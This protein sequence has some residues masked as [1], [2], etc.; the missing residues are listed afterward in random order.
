MTKRVIV[1]GAS[2]GIGKE[3]AWIL[4][5]SHCELVLVARR[6]DLLREIAQQCRDRGAVSA[7]VIAADLSES[8]ATCAE[9]IQEAIGP[10]ISPLVL[11]NNAGTAEFGPYAEMDW[12][13]IERSMAL[14]VLG[15]MRLCHAILPEMLARGGGQIVNVLS[16]AATHVFPNSG[17]YSAAKAGLLAF[18][19]SLAASHRRQGIRV[20]SILPGSVDTPLWDGKDWSPP[21]EDMLSPRT[22]AEVIRDA[23]MSP[24]DRNYDEIVLMP[25]KGIL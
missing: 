5:E 17:A 16:I 20:T 3:A 18:G 1:T 15:P 12:N 19:R 21:S 22:V 9:V 2:S 24:P 7:D 23:I 10:G 14:N 8:S 11:V 13:V 6:E 25:P 4:S